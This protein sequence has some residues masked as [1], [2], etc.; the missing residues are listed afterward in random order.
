[1]SKP[2]H[3]QILDEVARDHVPSDID[4][5]PGISARISQKGITHMNARRK[6]LWTAIWV[7]IGL[8]V[9]STTAYALYNLFFDPGLLAVQDAGLG[10]KPEITAR[11]TLLPTPTSNPTQI[12]LDEWTQAKNGVTLRLDSL[13]LSEMGTRLQFTVHGLA[14]GQSLDLPQVE[15]IGP[16]PEQERGASL[17]L[18][19]EGSALAGTFVSHQI[20]RQGVVDHQ[21]DVRISVPL[22][23]EDGQPLTTFDYS[24]MAVP[25]SQV[26]LP[27]QQ[28]YSV[29]YNGQE[30]T[31]P[32]IVISP[33]TTRI[34]VCLVD[35]QNPS[36]WKVSQAGLTWLNITTGQPT[37]PA[38]IDF[39]AA[40]GQDD[41]HFLTFDTPKGADEG[42]LQLTIREIVDG[43]GNIRTGQW[44][45]YVDLPGSN[46]TSSSM[47][48]LAAE[49]IANLTA[50]LNW[51]YADAN[52]AAFE[53]KFENWQAEYA[54]GNI[55]GTDDSGNL[56]GY[57]YGMPVTPDD[58]SRVI[59]LFSPERPEVWQGDQIELNLEI[60][61]NAAP[62]F[63]AS[64]AA[65]HFNLDLPVYP[66]LT[67]EP[68]ALVTAN[69]I[70]MRLEKLEIS[71]SY[72]LVTLCYQKPT[73]TG[74]SDWG[75]FRD[76]TLQ[77][78]GYTVSLDQYALLAD[79]D[80][81]LKHPSGLVLPEGMGRCVEIG[82]PI[83]HRNQAGQAAFT[84]IIPTLQLSLPEVIA[85]ADI[86][87]ANQKLAG[88]GLE[89]TYT[90]MTNSNGGAAG[91]V[92][93]RKPEGMSDVEAVNRLYAALRYFHLGP[94]EFELTV[95]P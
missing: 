79:A 95:T 14:E 19:E 2:T 73:H 16:L 18:V 92:I 66:N 63:A 64:V 38:L 82:F 78:G 57:G 91:P 40:A 77:L 13:S 3:R 50:T 62:D 35:T 5:L 85:D 65:F 70:E 47:A 1:M 28:T 42:V 8:V 94:W 81:T 84:L 15:Y 54:L 76:A 9:V 86:A 52:R 88:E 17:S 68:A 61:V 37:Q 26:Q 24:L 46:S 60:Q 21:V 10:T 83:G 30:L 4:L 48:P 7:L 29:R 89:F 55:L 49:T 27:G 6:L 43:E 53:V 39:V 87:A 71:P 59:I 23:G 51:A 93:L 72:S 74:N 33:Q 25:V 45:F 31:A 80:Y 90:S 56:L 32:Q 44:D 34:L 41:C 75:I 12:P 20:L 11:P 67:L 36:A 58:P 69:G 22:L